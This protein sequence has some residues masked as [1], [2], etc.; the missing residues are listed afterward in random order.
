MTTG[1]KIQHNE[2]FVTTVRWSPSHCY[3]LLLSSRRQIV[4]YG[5]TKRYYVLPYP[6]GD[7]SDTEQ[8]LIS[9]MIK[10]TVCHH[11]EK[12]KRLMYIYMGPCGV[13]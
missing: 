12:N 8:K 4:G 3:N 6:Q 10:D 2:K 5:L 7:S 9:L 13:I 11:A 1:Y